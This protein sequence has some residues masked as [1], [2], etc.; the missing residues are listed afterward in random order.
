LNT[1][2]TLEYWTACMKAADLTDKTIRERLIFIR[3]LARDV[4]DLGTVTRK[5][6]IVWTAAQNWSKF[7]ACASPFRA[8]YV[9][10]LVAGR[11]TP[12]RQSG[13]PVAARCHEEA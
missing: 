13:V 11:R 10:R 7:H 8:A 5:E 12:G 6:L 2:D 9:L 3:Q 1:N 4:D